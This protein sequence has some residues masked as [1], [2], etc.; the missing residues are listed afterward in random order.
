MAGEVPNSYYMNEKTPNT[1]DNMKSELVGL[2]NHK[3]LLEISTHVIN[4]VL[5]IDLFLLPIHHRKVFFGGSSLP[6]MVIFVSRFRS[7][8]TEQVTVYFII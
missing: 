3:R 2:G 4:S 1:L 6:R 5:S 7:K 8:F